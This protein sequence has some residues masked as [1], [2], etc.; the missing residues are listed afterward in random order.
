MPDAD[1]A[2]G[3]APRRSP[4]TVL[5]SLL[6]PSR[7]PWAA[8]TYRST[9]AHDRRRPEQVVDPRRRL[10][11]DLHAAARHHDRER[12]AARHRH[13]PAS[14]ASAT[15]SGSSTPTRS[16]LAALL[17]TAGSLADLLGRRRRSSRSGSAC[18]RSPRCCARCRAR[19][20]CSTS[21]A[22][23]QGVGG[24]AM[25]ATSLALI[26]AGVPGARARH[27]VRHLGRDD[28]RRRR[29]R[30]ARRRRA[31][32]GHRLAVRSSSSTC[33]SAS[34]RS[35]VTLRAR[36]RVARR[37]RRARSTGPASSTF[38][39]GLFLLVFAL[40]RGNEEGWGEPADRRLPG[41]RRRAARRASWRSRRAAR[42]RCST[43]SLFRKPT[44]GGAS[45]AA[46]ALSASMFAM[47]L[48][49]TL[50]IQNILGYRPLRGR[51]ALPA[52]ARWCRSS[53][54]RVAGKLA[55]RCRC[56]GCS[57]AG[58][59]SSGAGLLLDARRRRR[60]RG[61]RRCCPASSS[62][63]SAS[64]WSTRRWRRRDRGRAAA[65]GGHGLGHQLDVPPGR[66]RHGHRRLRRALPAPAGEQ[67]ERAAGPRPRRGARPRGR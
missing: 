28:R 30:A 43:S 53:S 39:G 6:T 63:A 40:I 31:D 44:F 14:R 52:V 61:G 12:R 47:F 45:I 38:S 46:F 24:A 1:V 5:L 33:R 42:S 7:P 34:P 60:R 19:R 32:A 66:H 57:A 8:R 56:A 29:D 15:C 4:A 37:A 35:F 23:L 10:R 16:T 36:G 48:Y 13:G 59:C 49:L 27:G 18:S 51:P 54:R 55:E 17:L 20:S 41:R 21:R 58:C 62:P 64:A 25:F 2:A 11:R 50:Y 3:C 9:D 22:A 26:A 67:G 65:A